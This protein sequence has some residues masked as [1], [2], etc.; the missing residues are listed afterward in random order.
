[1]VTRGGILPGT[2]EQKE[3]IKGNAAEIHIQSGV[4]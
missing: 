1:M 3:D 2:L 4:L